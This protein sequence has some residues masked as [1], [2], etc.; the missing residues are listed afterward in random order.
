MKTQNFEWI[1]DYIFSHH[2]NFEIQ[3]VTQLQQIFVFIRHRFNWNF[4]D[5]IVTICDDC[6]WKSYLRVLCSLKV[7]KVSRESRAPLNRGRDRVKLALCGKLCASWQVRWKL[8][9]VET[10][11]PR[12][13][14]GRV[15]KS[16]PH[17]SQSRGEEGENRH[18][19]RGKSYINVI[20][21]HF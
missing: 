9:R 21:T 14:R 5:N 4:T 18:A 16:M 17:T 2:E 3:F 6:L 1:Y 20:N 8:L 11:A 7:K 12:S 15:G 13:K 10:C 19:S